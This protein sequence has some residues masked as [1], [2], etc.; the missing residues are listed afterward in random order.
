MTIITS[1]MAAVAAS[2]G[3]FLI[4]ERRW[5][6]EFKTEFIAEKAVKKLLMHENWK[7]RSFEEISKKIGGFE[8]DKLR[9]LLVRAGAVRFYRTNDNK[10]LWGL[11]SR[12]E[13][14]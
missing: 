12:N 11:L 1:V 7:Q 10:E 5:R 6:K 4:Q 9:K 2:I 14:K 3:A 8:D 13:I